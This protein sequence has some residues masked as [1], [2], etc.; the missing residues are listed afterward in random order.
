[1]PRKRDLARIAPTEVEKTILFLRGQRV[2]LDSSLAEFYGVPTKVVNQ[3]V[4]RNR[5][6]FPSDFAFR[7]T[8]QEFTDLRSQIVT[9]NVGRGGQRLRSIRLHR[10]RRRHALRRV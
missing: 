8:Q 7:L 3:A 10:A 9:S 1:M 5:K 6:R 4:R 2:I